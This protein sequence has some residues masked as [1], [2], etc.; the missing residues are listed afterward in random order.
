[1]RWNRGMSVAT[2]LGLLCQLDG[3]LWRASPLRW[4][5][6]DASPNFLLAVPIPHAVCKWISDI[7]PMFSLFPTVGV[8]VPRVVSW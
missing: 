4:F 3:E 6:T 2:R 5:Y 7:F 1:M 8:R